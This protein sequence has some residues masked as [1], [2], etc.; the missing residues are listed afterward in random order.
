M[1][2]VAEAPG[3]SVTRTSPP[4]TWQSEGGPFAVFPPAFPPPEE[5]P[6][7]VPYPAEP[8]DGLVPV[9][10][11]ELVELHPNHAAVE[12]R[13]SAAALPIVIRIV[14]SQAGRAESAGLA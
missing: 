5:E 10:S 11:P 2:G 4:T 14:T 3:A 13:E 12:S 1:A 9:E 7:P 6:V 8:P